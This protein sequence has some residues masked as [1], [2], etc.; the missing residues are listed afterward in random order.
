MATLPPFW[1]HWRDQNKPRII[2]FFALGAPLGPKS[3][4]VNDFLGPQVSVFCPLVV[5]IA[6]WSPFGVI[7][8][9][10]WPPL[11][12]FWTHL[13]PCWPYLAQFSVPFGAIL[14]HLGSFW[15]PLAPF[16]VPFKP[17]LAHLGPL[18]CVSAPIN[19]NKRFVLH[20][21]WNLRGG[22]TRVSVFNKEAR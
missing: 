20:S 13:G 12:P 10:S 21:A 14:S 22:G 3:P 6:L 1:P 11:G 18:W 19:K 4:L 9:A 5:F 17:I 15:C 2:V 8:C 16:S 7:L